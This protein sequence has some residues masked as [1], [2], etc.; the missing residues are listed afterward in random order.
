MS[1]QFVSLKPTSHLY[2]YYPEQ[3]FELVSIDGK[4]ANLKYMKFDSYSSIAVPVDD[5]EPVSVSSDSD[6]QQQ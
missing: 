6:D 3:Q 5:V 4:M 2:Q 1:S